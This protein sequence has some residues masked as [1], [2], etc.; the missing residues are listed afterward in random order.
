[1]GE[2]PTSSRAVLVETYL[3]ADPSRP[4]DQPNLAERRRDFHDGQLLSGGA[5]L[6]ELC[7]GFPAHPQSLPAEA[8]RSA[9]ARSAGDAACAGAPLPLSQSNLLA[10]DFLPNLYPALHADEPGGP[11]DWAI[12]SVISDWR[13]AAR[14]ACVWLRGWLSRLARTRCCGWRGRPAMI[15]S[16]RQYRGSL[17]L[18]TGLGAADNDMGPSWSIWNATRWLIFCLTGR[19]RPW[20][21][22]CASILEL[23]SWR[24]IEPVLMRTAC[25]RAHQMPRKSRIVGTCCAILV[26]QFVPW[27]TPI[28]P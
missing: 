5:T 8:L 21:D 23:R 24:A 11:N 18:M 15:T 4:G 12:C 7:T 9:F 28:M 26:T 13:S 16:R 2:H 25:V 19:L 14:L 27:S 3:A 6:P 1:M 22:G 20:Q 17:P 10:A